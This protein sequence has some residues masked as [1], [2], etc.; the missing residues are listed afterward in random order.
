[1]QSLFHTDLVTTDK[2]ELIAQQ[3]EVNQSVV[4]VNDLNSTFS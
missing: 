3:T 1:M 4:C 2:P